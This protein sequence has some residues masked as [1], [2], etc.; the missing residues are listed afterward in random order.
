MK[1]P[2]TPGPWRVRDW[3]VAG[4]WFWA[5]FD[6]NNRTKFAK[7]AKYDLLLTSKAPEMAELLIELLGVCGPVNMGILQNK[8]KK[9]L[10]EIGFNEET[11]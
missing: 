3:S 1:R 5:N 9:L 4:G 10:K 8:I 7:T 2:W 11:T 6:S